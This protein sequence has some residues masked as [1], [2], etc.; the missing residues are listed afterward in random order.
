MNR[1]TGLKFLGEGG[2]GKVYRATRKYDGKEIALK[3]VNVKGVGVQTVKRIQDEI[4]FLKILSEPRC[5]PF[6]ICYYGSYYDDKERKI[7][8]EMEYID[9]KEMFDFVLNRAN[10]NKEKYY[11]LLM[12]T[13]KD[14][15]EGLK[16]IHGKGIIHNDIKLENIM[17]ENKT[18]IPK[19]IDFGLGCLYD[20]TVGYCKDFGGTL[21][22]MTP[23]M[24]TEPRGKRYP[25]SDMWA[26]GV[27][28]YAAA[29]K[30]FPMPE[31]VNMEDA[32][33]V[34]KYLLSDEPIPRLKTSNVYLNKIVNGLVVRHKNLRLTPDGVIGIANQYEAE[35]RKKRKAK[36]NP[37]YH[38]NNPGNNILCNGYQPYNCPRGYKY[39]YDDG[40]CHQEITRKI[41]RP[42]CDMGY[43]EYNCPKG[44]IFNRDDECCYPIKE[45]ATFDP[46]EKETRVQTKLLDPAGVSDFFTKYM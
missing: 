6:V 23:E 1:Y 24:L 35:L 11:D 30:T 31:N 38:N 22:Y 2:Q 15:A 32:E 36:N 19:I 9:G 17:I 40:C 29:T 21:I 39:N 26:L 20:K 46:T 37:Y 18:N 34:I 8:I 14:L 25:A 42:L 28:L 13:A 10:N 41:R 44:Y 3:I 45:P 5:N 16:Y 7:Y 4:E 27:S 12:G 33:D 43:A